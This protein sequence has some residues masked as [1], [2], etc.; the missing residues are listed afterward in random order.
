M[1]DSDSPAHQSNRWRGQPSARW[2]EWRGLVLL[3]ALL[4]FLRSTVVDWNHVPTRSMVPSIIPGD[5]IFVDKTAFGL[6]LPFS[7]APLVRWGAPTYSDIV[8]FR[9]PKTGAL[10][11]KRIIGLPGDRVSWRNNTL[12]LN[13]LAAL[14]TGSA[15]AQRALYLAQHF[16]HTET[17]REQISGQ[18]R[19]IL[20]YKISPQK[21]YGSF[22]PVV[23]P[24]D[25]Y[26][27]LGD[28]RDNSA[29]YRKFGFVHADH[30]VG[31]ASGVLFSL[32]PERFY[33][34]RWQ[35]F[36]TSFSL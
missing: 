31:R 3:I 10:T 19:M 2:Q 8:V 5:R 16:P 28:N 7:E 18:D 12:N 9:A 25:H 6:R 34:P 33:M 17:L 1:I 14:Y 36:A 23:V 27:V 30:L 4:I 11:V 35:R 15:G 26:L 20:R 21:S 32:D 22:N 24:A 13:G 29:D